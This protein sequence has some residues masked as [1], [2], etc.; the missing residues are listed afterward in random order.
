MRSSSCPSPARLSRRPRSG[1]THA[2]RRSR[3][4]AGAIRAG[5]RVIGLRPGRQSA[6]SSLRVSARSWLPGAAGAEMCGPESAS[7]AHC[8]CA[9]VERGA[10]AM[11]GM[12]RGVD[13]GGSRRVQTVRATDRDALS[14]R[15]EGRVALWRRRG[16]ASDRA[17]DDV[18][19]HWRAQRAGTTARSRVADLTSQLTVGKVCADHL[20]FLVRVASEH[21]QRPLN[22]R[23]GPAFLVEACTSQR[24]IG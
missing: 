21:Q 14:R 10:E 7:H 17:G 5:I 15:G 13:A 24:S 12:R 23:D 3:R 6:S 4:A 18:R 19:S 9:T 20:V 11:N 16:D 2:A 1:A 8:R 22:G